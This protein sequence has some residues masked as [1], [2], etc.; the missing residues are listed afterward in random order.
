M[1]VNVTVLPCTV[2]TI[3]TYNRANWDIIRENLLD[4]SDQYFQLN[5]TTFR[6]IY[7]NWKFFHNHFLTIIH[8]HIPFKYVCRRIHLSWMTTEIKH[9]IKKG[10]RCTTELSYT[11]VRRTGQSINFYKN[12]NLTL[13]ILFHLQMIKSLSG[14]I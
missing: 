6:S 13:Q 5:D 3:A 1:L 14:D 12:I 9:L 11:T 10:N 4:I 7:E 2:F 8:D